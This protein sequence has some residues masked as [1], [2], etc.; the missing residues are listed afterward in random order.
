MK[1]FKNQDKEY[2]EGISIPK[3][4]FLKWLDNYWYHY[5]WVTIGV[6]FF[7]T[8]IT[9]CTLQMCSQSADDL[10]VV[11][12][13]RNTLSA[14]EQNNVS[15]VMESL[16]PRDFD[17]NGETVISLNAFGILS[18]EQVEEQRA[19]TDADGKSTYVDNGYNSKQFETYSNY[20]MTGESSVLLLDPWL[21]ESLVSAGRLKSLEDALGYVPESAYGEYGVRLGDTELYSSY[22]VMRLLH[23]DTVICLLQPYVAGNSSKEEYYARELEMFEALVSYGEA[24]GNG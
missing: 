11:Y 2:T 21:Y 20:I 18:E 9:V 1:E 17:E 13:G 23:E 22:S 7:V 3:G 10:I 19:Q 5:K 24:E 8:V 6:A 4:K 15:K 12:A 14:E 16:A